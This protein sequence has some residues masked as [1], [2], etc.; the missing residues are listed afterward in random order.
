MEYDR[1]LKSEYYRQTAL[2]WSRR[3]LEKWAVCN[4]ELSLL[5]L[6]SV[7]LGVVFIDYFS[8]SKCRA[9]LFQSSRSL[10]NGSAVGVGGCDALQRA[11]IQQLNIAF[12]NIIYWHPFV[13]GHHYKL[14]TLQHLWHESAS[15]MQL[16]CSVVEIYSSTLEPRSFRTSTIEV[17]KGVCFPYAIRLWKLQHLCEMSWLPICN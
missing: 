13:C 15:H 4:L 3:F 8:L 9:D 11:F 14:W 7:T 17:M 6:L 2:F 10:G 16:G 1:V 5:L 12:L